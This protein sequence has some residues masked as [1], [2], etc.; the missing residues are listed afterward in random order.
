MLTL[1]RQR[2]HMTAQVGPFAQ[3]FTLAGFS[4]VRDGDETELNAL[5]RTV[6]ISGDEATVRNRVHELVA[7]G[8]DE[9][10]LKLVPIADE[11]QER[12]Q[13]LHLVGS[14]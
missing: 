11:A 6:M 1:V 2:L 5:A 12:K 13:L 7:G 8:L 14:F 10:L 4:R 9:L 3:M